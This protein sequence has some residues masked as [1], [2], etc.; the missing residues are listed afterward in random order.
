MKEKEVRSGADVLGIR[1]RLHNH[2]F[3]RS[4]PFLSRA[5]DKSGWP[6]LANLHFRAMMTYLGM[7]IWARP[8]Q[9]IAP[10]V[11]GWKYLQRDTLFPLR[12]WSRKMR[13]LRAALSHLSLLGKRDAAPRKRETCLGA[14][15]EHLVQPWE[16]K[17]TPWTSHDKFS[18]LI[19]PFSWLWKVG[20]KKGL[21]MRNSLS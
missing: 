12:S 1:F 2:L 11:F 17:C 10:Q 15:F 20:G 19:S 6:G 13:N 14:S 4:S 8:G 21:Q 7:D 18:F 16:A 9:S 5:P 3:K